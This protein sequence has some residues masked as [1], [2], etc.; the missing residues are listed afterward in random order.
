MAKKQASNARKR[1]QTS[2]KPG[3]SGNPK[4]RPPSEV[5]KVAREHS[6]NALDTVLAIM[7]DGN[8][9]A[10]ERLR[11]ARYV[12][13]LSRES[14]ADPKAPRTIAVEFTENWTAPTGDEGHA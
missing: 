10:A 14:D 2:W 11:A 4:G 6:Q 9:D 12:I 13:D 8:A 5:V 1:N 7:R 3:Q